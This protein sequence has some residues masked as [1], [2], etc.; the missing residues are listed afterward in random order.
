MNGQTD[1]T[2]T[3]KGT[4]W[5][6]T[7]FNKDLEYL[8]K[9]QSGEEPM[10]SFWKELAGGEE[11]CGTTKRRH[12]QGCLHTAETRMSKIKKVLPTANIQKLK[13]TSEK[14]KQYAMKSETAVGP[15]TIVKNDKYYSMEDVLLKCA[16]IYVEQLSEDVDILCEDDCGFRTIS[17]RLVRQNF[18]LVSLCSQPQMA[19]AWKMYYI[20]IIN[21]YK[22]RLETTE[23]QQV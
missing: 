19:R 7:A 1:T 13:S 10:P 15:K 17:S 23:E 18:F 5:C 14:L 22:E 8:L 4:W 20:A 21:V 9:V 16:E 3:T 11:E 12:F 2:T 6:I